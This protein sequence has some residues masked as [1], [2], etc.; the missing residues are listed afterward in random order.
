MPGFSFASGNV[1]KLAAV[2]L[3]ALG[4]AASVLIPRSDDLWVFGCGSGIG[5]AVGVA[6]GV[7]VGVEVGDGVGVGVAV[8]VGVNVGVA[9]AKTFHSESGPSV[10]SESAPAVAAAT[11]T[12]A[13]MASL[14]ASRLFMR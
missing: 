7:V 14:R 1:K 10:R 5:V 12:V 8:D 2:P 6:V 3:Y 9:A 4:A 13:A 11:M